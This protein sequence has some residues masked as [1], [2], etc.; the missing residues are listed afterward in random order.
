MASKNKKLKPN[1]MV[2]KMPANSAWFNN[3]A[4]S[5]GFA[6][7]DLVKEVMPNT[8]NFLEYNNTAESIQ[9]VRDMRMNTGARNTISKQL[10][11]IPQVNLARDGLKNALDDI[12]SGKIWND[13]RGKSGEFGFDDD[14]DFGFGDMFDDEDSISFDDDGDGGENVTVNRNTVN[15]VVNTLPLAKTMAANTEA[16]INAMGSIA[17][18][19]AAIETEKMMFNNKSTASIL[20][21]LSAIN[22]NLSAIVKFQGDAT[23]KYYAASIKYYEESLEML[24]KSNGVG[25][26]EE[27]KT[28][29]R[30]DL[31]TYTGSVKM[32]NY[33][34]IIKKN[35]EDMKDESV[36]MSGMYDAFKDLNNIKAISNNPLGFIV[37]MGMRSVIPIATKASIQALDASMSAVLPALLAKVNDMGDSDNPLYQYINKV[38]GTKNKLSYKVDLGDYEKGVIGFDGESKKAL[39]EVI[40]TH[41]RRIEAAL[42]GKEE[43]MFDY[44][45]GKF[46]NIGNIKKTYEQNLREKEVSGYSDARLKLKSIASGMTKDKKALDQ[47]DKDL[48]EY[49]SAIT[50]KGSMINPFITETNGIRNDAL[51]ELGLFDGDNRRVE[52]VRRAFKGL[53]QSDILKMQTMGILDSRKATNEFMNDVRKN[54]NISN[55]NILNNKGLYDDK[56]K[57]TYDPTKNQGQTDKFGFTSVD[58]LRDIRK[59][60][61]TGIVV[62]PDKRKRYKNNPNAGMAQRIADEEKARG[63]VE[64]TSNALAGNEDDTEAD[65]DSILRLSDRTMQRIYAE[66]N[67]EDKGKDNKISSRISNIPGLSK[68]SDI[69]SNVS[70]VIDDATYRMVFGEN[71]DSRNQRLDNIDALRQSVGA[72]RRD[73]G[74]VL[75]NIMGSLQD[76]VKGVGA[77]FTG[78][79][80]VK[81][82]GTLVPETDDGLLK[83]MTRGLS[84]GIDSLFGTKNDSE[85]VG[86]IGRFTENF[87]LGFKEFKATLFGE[88]RLTDKDRQETLAQ[89]TSKIKGRLPK[90]IGAGLTGAVVKTT[91]ASHMG[92]LGSILLPGGPLGAA[93]TGLSFGLLSQS[94]TFKSW[95]FGTKNDAGKRMGGFIPKSLV[96]MIEQNGGTIK[97]G[98]IIG[99]AAGLLPSF[100]LPGGPVTGAILGIGTGIASKSNMFQ[101]FLY[102]P[103]FKS[104][105]KKSLMDGKFGQLYKKSL[106]KIN[107]S[108]PRL[109]AFL[110]AGGLGIGLA[111]GVGLLPSMLLP[112]GPVVGSLIGLAGG[113]AASSD[114]FQQF[115]FGD[116]DIDGKRYGGLMTQ[117]TNW[118]DTTVMSPMKIKMTEINDNIYGFVKGK[119]I[120]PVIDAFAPLTQ[121]FKFAIDDAKNA[122]T[123]TWHKL[124]DGIIGSFNDNVVKPFGESLEKYVVDPMKKFFNKTLGLLGKTLGALITSPIKL[125]TTLGNVA[126]FTNERRI[127]KNE[128]RGRRQELKDAIFTDDFSFRNLTTAVG[129]Q[130]IGKDEKDKILNRSLPYRANRESNRQEREDALKAEM[131]ARKAKREDMQR[132]YEEDRSFGRS[133]NW[134][135]ASK[136][137]KESREQELKEKQAWFQEQIAIKEKEAVEKLTAV[138]STLDRIPSEQ[139]E[140]RKI[141]EDM[142]SSL[143]TVVKNLSKIGEEEGGLGGKI[144]SGIGNTLK[145]NNQSHADGLDTVPNDGYIAELHEGEMVVP[146]K[147]AKT[148][149]NLFGGKKDKG[150][151]IVQS[152]TDKL[153]GTKEKPSI[154]GKMFGGF[155]DEEEH[156]FN[157]LNMTRDQLETM[158]ELEDRRRYKQASRKNVDF[159]QQKFEERKKDKED[160]KFR[161][162]LL[163]AIEKGFSTGKNATDAGT[164]LLKKIFNGGKAILGSILSKIGL[165]G[166]LGMAGALATGGFF[167]SKMSQAEENDSTLLEAAHGYGDETRKDKDG[168]YVYDNTPDVL[169]KENLRHNA[170]KAYK[171]GKSGVQGARNAYNTMKPVAIGAKNGIQNTASKLGRSYQNLAHPIQSSGAGQI[172]DAAGNVVGD[173]NYAVRGN[174]TNGIGKYLAK[175]EDFLKAGKNR[176]KETISMLINNGKKAVASIVDA[177]G[178][179]VPGVKSISGSLDDIFSKL[180]T[181]ADDVFKRYGSKIKL[182]IVDGAADFI[183]VAGQVAEVGM[184]VWD[185]ATGLTKGNAA[186]LFQ[187]PQDSV[188]G[189]MRTICS[190]MQGLCKF[191][192]FSIIWLL[193]EICGSMFNF[194]FL[195]TV[196][197]GLYQ[198]IGGGVGRK[199]DFS[200][201]LKGVDTNSMSFNDAFVKAGGNI[202]Q[203]MDKN[204]KIKDISKLKT[205]DLDGISAVEKQELERLQYN[206]QNGTKLSSQA[207]ND[208]KNKTVGQK[209]FGSKWMK[210]LKGSTGLDTTSARN[211]L[212]L[213][214]GAKVTL[215]DRLQY[216]NQKRGINLLNFGRK[217]IGKEELDDKKLMNARIYDEKGNVVGEKTG[218]YTYAELRNV[219][220]KDKL[221]KANKKLADLEGKSGWFSGLQTKYYES[222]RDK[223]QGRLGRGGAESAEEARQNAKIK[224]QKNKEI[225]AK[226]FADS[227]KKYQQKWEDMKSGAGKAWNGFT[228]SVEK[229]KNNASDWITGKVDGVKNKVKSGIDWAY[230]GT[231]GSAGTRAAQA[232]KKI[233]KYVDDQ[234]KNGIDGA[235]KNLDKSLKALGGGFTKLGDNIVTMKDDLFG[236]IEDG[237]KGFTDGIGNLKD[238][239][240]DGFKSGVKTVGDAFTDNFDK[241]K[242][243]TEK[244]K[245]NIQDSLSKKLKDLGESSD[246]LSD[247]VKGVFDDIKGK[248]SGFMDKLKEFQLP[249]WGT[250]TETVSNG[251]EKAGDWIGE[252]TAPVRDGAKSI[253]SNMYDFYKEITKGD[254]A[255]KAG[256]AKKATSSPTLSRSS[257][258]ESGQFIN[259]STTNNN[260]TNN[261]TNNKF[262]FYSQNDKEWSNKAIGDKTMADAGCGPTSI[263]MAISQM[264]GEQITPDVIASLGKKNLPGY[265]TYGLFPEIAK[266]FGMNYEDTENQTDVLSY[267]SQGIPVILS[268]K[269]GDINTPFTEDGHIV[270]ANKLEGDKVFVSDPRGKGYSKYYNVNDLFNGMRKGI[271][272]K[273]TN[274]TKNRLS[275][276]KGRLNGVPGQFIGSLNTEISK[277][278]L[279]RA[280]LSSNLGGDGQIKLYEKVLGYAKAFE[281]KLQYNY[282]SKAI[283]NNKLSSDCS[284][285]TRHVFKRAADIDIGVGSAAQHNAGSKVDL[286]QAQ[287]ADLIVFDGHAGIVWDSNKNMI[288]IGSGVGPTIKS[289]DNSYWRGRNPIIR[290]VLSDPNQLVNGTISN[291]N[292]ALG[293]SN[294]AG[295]YSGGEISGGAP[296][297]ETSGGAAPAAID[298]LGVF[299]KLGQ[300]GQNLMASIFNGKQVDLFASPGVAD[301]ASTDGMDI[302]GISNVKQAVWQFFTSKGYSKEATAG[303]MGNMQAE[304]GINPSVIQNNG[305]GPA[306]GIA[307][308]E[309]YNQKNQ[310]WGQMA[311]HAKS[312]GKEWTDLQSQLEFIDMELS[313]AGNVDNYTSYLLKKNYGGIEGFKA[314]SDVGVAT[315]AFESSFERAG[316]KALPKRTSFANKI[317]G[318]MMNNNAG[319]GPATATSAQSAPSDGSIPNSM[320]G[321]AYYKQGDARWNSGSIGG[322]TVE[323]AGCGPTSH[324]MMLTTMF[325]KQITP[326]TMTKYALSKGGW[327]SSGMGWNLPSIVAKDFGLKVN[328]LTG[329]KSDA[330]LAHIKQ[331]IKAGRP[332]IM[333]GRGK[334]NDLNTP[335]TTGGHIVLGVGVDGNGNIIINDPRDPKYTKAY[336]DAGMKMGTGLRGS[337]SFDMGNGA[338]IPNGFNVG[339]DFVGGGMSSGETGGAAP[340]AIDPLGAF[341]KM[342]QIGQ[343]MM[344]SIFNGKQVDLF[345]TQGGV[346][347]T[348][349]TGTGNFPRYN[350]NEQ[351][352]KGIANILDHEQPGP[353]GKQAEASLMANLTDKSGDQNATVD[354]LIAKATG[355]WFAYGKS[356]FSNPGSPS[357]EAI[358]AVRSVLV[359]GRRTL[360]RYVDEH[361]CFSDIRSATNDGTAISKTNRGQYKQFTTKIKNV[362]G[363]SGTFHSFPNSKSDPFYYTSEEL[364]RKWGENHYP[365]T[366][367]SAGMGD[368][369]TYMIKPNQS[370]VRYTGSAGK[371]DGNAEATLRKIKSNLAQS[372]SSDRGIGTTNNTMVFSDNSV[373]K[374][375]IEVLSSV[376]EELK[377]INTNTAATANNTSK[378]TVYSENTPVKEVKQ[379]KQQRKNDKRQANDNT[380]YNV[381]RTIAGFMK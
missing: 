216:G 279:S 213:Q 116:K 78:K 270:V 157:P 82:D 33:A 369:N 372:I 107:S 48:Q 294:V 255:G 147:G 256:I 174:A 350:L 15:N 120:N 30:D 319:T 225:A 87:M 135:Y 348:S 202:N 39:V 68:V 260:T 69:L 231:S 175:G 112:G 368:G 95:L 352:I 301:A 44:T 168:Y 347:T 136:R 50:K 150:N 200:N 355:G 193:N 106:G 101:E 373:N 6:A 152:I 74:S 236:K 378:L 159:I 249:S 166:A 271:V 80:Y 226:K 31:Y 52:M 56:G 38:F 278:F 198:A 339:G 377:A 187:V 246:K 16:T 322:T 114:K 223:A 309:N 3:V 229:T 315:K 381:A 176:A 167:A 289:Y 239:A 245:K 357:Q 300:I 11:N 263:A 332:V 189:E 191:S 40:P 214:K 71:Y 253:L 327:S 72:G 272:M 273:P 252:K 9:L 143:R 320:N 156:E 286:N 130:F 328:T 104:G 183:P 134:K 201:D 305:R 92:M 291:P 21:G 22:D 19:H 186:N 370:K 163:A 244:T 241:F 220:E 380:G 224:T 146:K 169:I 184:T 7:A 199:I 307:Q 302:S 324:A 248:M 299:G 140:Q 5:M 126:N 85:D 25:K 331:E 306:A 119:V 173:A 329:G 66:A 105:N 288:D 284:A 86:M 196:A 326:D 164:D 155:M 287:P 117:F 285:F 209:I 261:S 75:S 365:A 162:D 20:G 312:K 60:L 265:S 10:R 234:V 346:D 379:N 51:A 149:R 139:L 128:R 228:D 251:V 132:Q 190:I 293:V 268:G 103:D 148:L 314:I 180:M 353:E 362:Y 172:L 179:K 144:L 13:E 123:N 317:Y 43:R 364:R 34:Q 337:W 4:K 208:M 83:K 254:N 161:M 81:H 158:N 109:S 282:G 222:K 58:Y 363:S 264:T 303:I 204:G 160:K 165:G 32:G 93:I 97:K 215:G 89:L 76:T 296:G 262:V 151:S 371:G 2:K 46:E 360:P 207:Y 295:L 35:L 274:A 59:M 298:P 318:E 26:N 170:P 45:T 111:Q 108:N 335:F 235:K 141:L 90:A 29:V 340:A 227:K 100:F 88:S 154:L 343:N 91:L 310:R 127:M 98:A 219:R 345:A 195:T 73:Q 333:S 171:L 237:Y 280:E 258:R 366:S 203:I 137:Q 344:A 77:Y 178:K 211:H 42:T 205:D 185:V 61:A 113:I 325:G 181:N 218:V 206:Q 192:W 1:Q 53:S 63:I 338:A 247:S 316:V 131:E 242:D 79:S 210:N 311:A 269:N 115:L 124:T 359:G 308:W 14:V 281:K 64:R 121:A 65:Y 243:K 62:H 212:G 8:S 12:K 118:F 321:W 358:D 49:F 138:N 290:R 330:A 197:R 24:K 133:S 70:K 292:T 221:D 313:G 334:S 142:A 145:D 376:V 233:D 342:G 41:L 36:V 84:G 297:A 351:Q 250:V 177:V 99:G 238:E 54:P 28:D 94:D 23:S 232:V 230:E 354:N 367:G 96:D 27:E 125:L 276:S 341:G 266:K 37:K 257:N 18:Q 122:M 283:D 323:R 349:A 304:S 55:Y 57:L 188:D 336:T 361:D 17:D 110:G 194:P 275:M 47:F 267:L 67:S 182:Y 217:L 129:R 102:G 356:R 259:P 277:D 375:C 153:M 240:V 374:A